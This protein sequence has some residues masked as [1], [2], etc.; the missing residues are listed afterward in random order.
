M[1]ERQGHA[2]QD[3]L[4]RGDFL[5]IVQAGTDVRRAARCLR[6]EA[7]LDVHPG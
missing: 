7:A 5:A 2:D 6:D 4:T 3:R 1:P